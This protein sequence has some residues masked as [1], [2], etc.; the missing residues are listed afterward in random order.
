MGCMEGPILEPDIEY[1]SALAGFLSVFS[2]EFERVPPFSFDELVRAGSRGP[3][4]AVA[5]RF[6]LHT[7]R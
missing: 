4:R 1:F 7:D 6:R 3:L 5:V 2:L